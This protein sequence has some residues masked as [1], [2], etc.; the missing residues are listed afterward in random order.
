M[1]SGHD[2]FFARWSRR[3]QAERRARPPIAEE[4]KHT[5]NAA[6]PEEGAEDCHLQVSPADPAANEP[7]EPLP[8]LED[9]TAESDLAAFLRQGVPE[10]LKSA[11]LRKMWSLDPAIRD[12]VGPAEYAWDFNQP[13]S[14]GGFG[15]LQA[16]KSVADVVST[17]SGAPPTASQGPSPAADT[18][19]GTRPARQ[20]TTKSSDQA[21]TD[22]PEHPADASSPGE[23]AEPPHLPAE[24]Q[25][26]PS[27]D[28]VTIA[29][30]PG[31]KSEP[32]DAPPIPAAP[33]HGS[34]VPR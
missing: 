25:S 26:P 32:A 5:A 2:N 8:S 10:A 17:M 33:R 28:G 18:P 14:M 34:A 12:Y 27:A 23:A 30:A 19:A 16:N 3:K 21:Q 29:A 11:A 4:E 22:P 20:V 7:A 24:A 31:E 6:P 15:P 9:L 1:S 13:G